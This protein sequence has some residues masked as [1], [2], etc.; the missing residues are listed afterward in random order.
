MRHGEQVKHRS[1]TVLTTVNITTCELMKEQESSACQLPPT[2]SNFK[3]GRERE[4]DRETEREIERERERE[5]ER[6]E[7]ESERQTRREKKRGGDRK[8]WSDS[9]EGGVKKEWE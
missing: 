8:R 1:G 5:R 6:G 9:R 3:G 2:V 4:R 7:R